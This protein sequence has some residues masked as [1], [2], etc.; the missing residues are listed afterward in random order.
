MEGEV[1]GRPYTS[2]RRVGSVLVMLRT[3]LRGHRGGGRGQVIYFIEMGGVL[4]SMRGQK[5][6][7]GRL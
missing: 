4:G 6:W 3:R 1:G 2:L 7:Q 5:G